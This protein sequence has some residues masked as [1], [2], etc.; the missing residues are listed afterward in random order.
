MS[1][2]A[3]H[4]AT[5]VLETERTA[6]AIAGER[7]VDVRAVVAFELPIA[8]GREAHRHGGAAVVAVAEGDHILVAGVFASREN[9]DFVRFAAAVREIGSRKSRRHFFGELLGELHNG[10]VKIDCCRVLQSAGLLANALHDLRVAVTDADRD[11]SGEAIQVLLASLVPHVLHVA[12][13]D[14][15]RIAVIR[16]NARRQ[17]L[18]A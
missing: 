16:D 14:H 7:V 2:G 12:F 17:I 3:L 15:Q 1:C 5:R 9:R 11:D 18:M 4:A 10:R 13:D 8:V 6:V